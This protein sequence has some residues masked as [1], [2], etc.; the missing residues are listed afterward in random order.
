MGLNED[1]SAAA[2]KAKN[3]KASPSNDE[4]L[5]LYAL[6]KQAEVGDVNTCMYLPTL[7]GPKRLNL[8]P[9][10]FLVRASYTK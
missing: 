7:G 10:F 9:T 5:E 2:A 6:F 4:L 1:F 3:L 8:L